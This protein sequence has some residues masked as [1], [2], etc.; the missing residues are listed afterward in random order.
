[1]KNVWIPL[2]GAIAQ[3]RKVETIA[4]NVA[5]AN[6]PGFKKDQ[7]VFKEYLTALDKGTSEIDLPSKEWAPEDFYRSYGAENSYVKIAGSYTSHAQGK[8][9]PT[10]NPLDVALQGNGFF[11]VLT[12]TGVRYTRKGI[13]ALN[14]NSELVTDQGFRVLSPLAAPDPEAQGDNNDQPAPTPQDRVLIL[15]KGTVAINEQ[16]EIFVN[17]SNAGK[18]SIVEFKDPTALV[19]EG[20]SLFVS[21]KAQNRLPESVGTK[22][23]QGFVEESNVNALNEMAELIKAHRH[24]DSIQRAIKSYDQISGKSV[25]DIL[26]F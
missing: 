20:N 19:K 25:N 14:R 26:R 8:L 17:G 2:S 6:T 1:M 21:N 11:E 4:N 10:Y 18:L 24:F 13:F 16:G 9:T 22:V 15:P 5:N 23:R 12:P 7:L 3:Q